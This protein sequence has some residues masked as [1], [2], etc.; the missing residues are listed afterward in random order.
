MKLLTG[1][2]RAARKRTLTT[3]NDMGMFRE[4]LTELVEK[5]AE[6]PDE[7]VAKRVD[8]LKEM[9]VDL[10]ESEDKSKLD[11]YLEDIKSIKEQDD[12]TAKEA[13]S[14][15]SDL[16]EKL[17]TEAMKEVD[18]GAET[19][20][21]AT[22]EVAAEEEAPLVESEAAPEA[23]EEATEAVEETVAPEEEEG[24][25]EDADPNAD[26]SLEEIY[27]FIKKRMAEDAACAED[28]AE[29]VEEEKEEDEEE[30]VVADHA[31][32]IPVTMNGTPAAQGG[33][34]DMFNKIK[35]GG[36]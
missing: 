21:E 34:A 14:M 12:A 19:T 29:E 16:F 17:D 24:K 2:F 30:E 26:Y 1:L 8:E 32:R 11:L 25:A 36:R 31:P 7:E 9:T 20:E 35:A 6:L 27:Q 23:T 5:K 18:G 15:V 10:P 13:A 22:E 33:L 3:D 4:K 28:S